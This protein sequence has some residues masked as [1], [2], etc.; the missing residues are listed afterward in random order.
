MTIHS[1]TQ[2]GFHA[3]FLHHLHQIPVADAVFAVPADTEQD[4]L[5]GKAPAL[6]HDPSYRHR[7]ISDLVKATQPRT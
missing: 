7:P 6:E 4:D 2:N 1:I 5:D 3:A